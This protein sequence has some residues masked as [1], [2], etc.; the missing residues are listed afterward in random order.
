VPVG[1][2]A[3]VGD[4]R[5]DGDG[6]WLGSTGADVELS[7]GVTVEGAVG[8]GD[9]PG[10]R[11]PSIRMDVSSATTSGRQEPVLRGTT[12][13]EVFLHGPAGPIAGGHRVAGATAHMDGADAG[14][15]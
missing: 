9:E 13:L 5:G 7:A 11:Q 6:E 4:G 14:R 12:M 1:L 8:A 15:R 2:A 10:A 3:G